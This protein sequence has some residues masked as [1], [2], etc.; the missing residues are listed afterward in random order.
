M[1]PRLQQYLPTVLHLCQKL[2]SLL[3]CQVNSW[4]AGQSNDGFVNKQSTFLRQINTTSKHCIHHTWK[5]WHLRHLFTQTTMLLLPPT[6]RL[7]EFPV[8]RPARSEVNAKRRLFIILCHTTSGSVHFDV[9]I[10]NI[11]GKNDVFPGKCV[12]YFILKKRIGLKLHVIFKLN[13]IFP[14]Y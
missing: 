1:S 7:R 5:H 12:Y 14:G 8:S 11:I 13:V 6:A 9:V 10:I 4:E 3:E 2:R